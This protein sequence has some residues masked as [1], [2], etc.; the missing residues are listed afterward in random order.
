L[1]KHFLFDNFWNNSFSHTHMFFYSL[2]FFLSLL[3]LSNK[4]REKVVVIKVKGCTKLVLQISLFNKKYIIKFT[5]HFP[6]Q[7]QI[8]WCIYT[9][10]FFQKLCYSS[11]LKHEW[12][13]TLLLQYDYPFKFEHRQDSKR[14]EDFSIKST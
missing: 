4:N 8:L 13:E 12:R 11:L 6:S 10:K 2:F 7:A 9:S 5:W 3:F 1:Y 14:Y